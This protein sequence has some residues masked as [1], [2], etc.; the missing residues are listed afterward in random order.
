[1]NKVPDY[2]T[3]T[4]DELE[5]VYYAVDRN[6]Y[7][8]NFRAIV[9]EIEKRKAEKSLDTKKDAKTENLDRLSRE[10]ITFDNCYC[11]SPLCGPSRISFATS[12]YFSEHNHRNYWSTIGPDV[13]N[14]VTLLKNSG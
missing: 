2:T 14:I 11:A 4:L 8:D 6:K 1:M 9:K 12:T 7:P 10:G 3:Y 13:P 5:D